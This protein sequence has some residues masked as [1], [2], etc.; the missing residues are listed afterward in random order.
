MFSAGRLLLLVA[1]AAAPL[2]AG[3]GISVSGSTWTVDTSGGLVFS[4]ECDGRTYPHSSSIT[5]PVNSANGDV[6][7]MKYNGVE[8]RTLISY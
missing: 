5:L 2:V 1:A 6:T 7:S 8:V 3:F 4:S